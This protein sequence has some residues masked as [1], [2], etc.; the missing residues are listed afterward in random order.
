MSIAFLKKKK[1]FNCIKPL[2]CLLFIRWRKRHIINCDMCGRRKEQLTTTARMSQPSS[3]WTLWA[4]CV[5]YLM[6]PS[7]TKCESYRST[8]PFAGAIPLLDNDDYTSD[9]PFEKPCTEAKVSFLFFFYL[10]S[11]HLLPTHYGVFLI[12]I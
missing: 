5:L 12:Y 11:V 2:F 8:D 1:L 3:R 9:N 4:F 10:K 6:A 7:P